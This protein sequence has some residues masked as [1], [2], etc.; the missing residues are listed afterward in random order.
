MKSPCAS[1]SFGL[2]SPSPLTFCWYRTAQPAELVG[3]LACIELSTHLQSVH[4]VSWS[5]GLV[6]QSFVHSEQVCTSLSSA[7][8]PLVLTDLPEPFLS[9]LSSTG[10]AP[11]SLGGS[12]PSDLRHSEPVAFSGCIHCL[13]VSP[14]RTVWNSGWMSECAR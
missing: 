13:D 14:I 2:L 7:I 4:T 12:T 1:R 8:V 3:L 10:F 9:G 11:M 5:S 6:T